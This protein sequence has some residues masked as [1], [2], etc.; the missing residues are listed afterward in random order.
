MIVTVIIALFVAA[1]FSLEAEASGQSKP[2]WITVGL[3]SY[4]I[5]M[6]IWS[7]IL[8]TVFTASLPESVKATIAGLLAVACG[9]A[10]GL[11]S[12]AI[13]RWEVSKKTGLEMKPNILLVAF[14]VL[15]HIALLA[16]LLWPLS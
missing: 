5:P 9:Q 8:S 16:L 15:A 14:T 12:A 11:L 4:L 2:F 1:W 10:I 3:L 6:F 13:V 7:A